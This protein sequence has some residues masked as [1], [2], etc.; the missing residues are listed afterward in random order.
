MHH[1]VEQARSGDLEAY[2]TLVERYE[3]TVF[4]AVL[5][6]T[7]DEHDAED[8]TQ[9]VFILGYQKLKQLR[10]MSRFP[11]WLLRVAR[12]EAI[13]VA[14]RERRRKSVII[15][16][17]VEP[18]HL[19]SDSSFLDES[20]EHLL[21]QVQRLPMHERVTICLRFFDGHSV[22]EIADMTGSPVGTVTKRLSR[23]TER[24]RRLLT[25]EAKR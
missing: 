23:A 16:D 7:R 12:R 4:A 14:K 8:V 18:S 24:L 15:T 13:R 1:I 3:R 6:I 22:R 11:H 17:S 20:K 5:D 9:D 2:G 10:D 25:S 21:R 19:D